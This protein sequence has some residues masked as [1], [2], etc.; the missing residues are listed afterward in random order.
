MTDSQA[1]NAKL[2]EQLRLC[3]LELAQIQRQQEAAAEKKASGDGLQAKFDQLATRLDARL[4]R[5]ESTAGN[6]GKLKRRLIP[7]MPRAAE[8]ADLAV[9]RASNLM[10]G[11]WYLQRYPE[12]A[13]SGLSAALHYLRHGAGENKDPG[14]LFST[15]KYR[16]Q[17][18][19]LTDDL[20]PLVHFHATKPESAQ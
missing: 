17:H 16:T 6:R 15:R 9:L 4:E 14:P 20:N 1:E 18:P 8:E 13:S 2:K 5:G 11:S 7:T 19:E 10:V 12:V 3:Q